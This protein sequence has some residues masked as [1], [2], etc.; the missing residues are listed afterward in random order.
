MRGDVTLKE[1]ASNVFYGWW[2]VIGG[3]LMQGYASVVFW[4][5]FQAFVNPILESFS[6]WSSAW[7]AAAISLQ[8]GESGLISPFVGAMIDKFGPKRVMLFGII[9]T[10]FGFITM[11]LMNSLWQFYLSVMLLALGMSFGTFIVFVATVGN[12]FVRLRARALAT[13]MTFSAVGALALPA[14]VWIIDTYGWRET[15][16]GVGIGFWILGAPLALLMRRRPEDYGLR[17]D[18]DAPFANNGDV[19]GGQDGVHRMPRELAVSVRDALRLRAF[20]QIA[21]ATSLGQLVSSSNLFHLPALL[22]YNIDIWLASAAA[23]AVAIGD[24]AG[25]VSIGIIGDRSSKKLLLAI[26]FAIQILG[27]G[28]LALINADFMGFNWGL[29]PLPVFV[30]GFGLGFGA[31]I[32]L[33]LAIL[34]DYFGRRSY[35][36]IVGIVSSV[37]AVF[38]IAGPL[39]VGFTFDLTQSYRPG[40]AI[41]SIVLIFAIPL[42][43]SLESHTRVAAKVRQTARAR[44][45]RPTQ[46]R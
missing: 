13:L 4:R 19:S 36:S 37:S 33:R 23:G 8:R 5:G 21:I 11:G 31:S 46:H 3:G 32:P 2:I 26:S 43:L 42:T 28:A 45:A 7:F 41:M 16:I 10:G 24:I 18:G 12:W 44:F 38:G 1:R 29:I 15:L 35:G 20:W 40:Y 17:P 14:L 39:L 30:M 6:G 34:A 25:R 27:V 22:D 9:V